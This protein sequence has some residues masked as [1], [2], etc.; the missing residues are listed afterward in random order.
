MRGR[1]WGAIPSP[2]FSILAL[3]VAHRGG[4]EGYKS[5]RP[6]CGRYC[7]DREVRVRSWEVRV[8]VGVGGGVGCTI[9]DPS[10]FDPCSQI[11]A[12]CRLP[13]TRMPN[14]ETAGRTPTG[15]DWRPA[16]RY[17]K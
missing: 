16:P 9:L 7:T 4:G 5:K 12:S 14:F 1:G 8:G 10:I 15:A 2:P 17:T 3:R 13:K 6:C 11:S